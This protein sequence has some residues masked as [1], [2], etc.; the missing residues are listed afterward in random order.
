MP[1]WRGDGHEIFYMALDYALMAVSVDGRS[2]AFQVGQATPLFHPRV[3]S[4]VSYNYAVSADGQRILVNAS[5]GRD[6]PVA[7]IEDWPALLPK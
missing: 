3:P 2:S 6:A 5:A 7:I 4:P 1:R